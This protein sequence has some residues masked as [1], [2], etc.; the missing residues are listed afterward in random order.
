MAPTAPVVLP[1]SRFIPGDLFRRPARGCLS[2]QTQDEPP[3]GRPRQRPVQGHRP[4]TRGNANKRRISSDLYEGTKRM[5]IVM[6]EGATP[7]Q[8]EAVVERGQAVGC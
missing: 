3:A 8:I 6:K 5:M 2:R 4:F 1:A 7:E